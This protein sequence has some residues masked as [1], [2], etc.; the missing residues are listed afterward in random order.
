MVNHMKTT[1]DIPDDLYRA[2]KAR[3]ALRGT[4]VKVLLTEALLE[5]LAR[6]AKTEGP[7]GW[8]SCFGKVSRAAAEEIQAVVDETFSVVDAEEWR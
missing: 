1:L 6:D 3:A 5:K 8:R 2:V 7:V 4:T